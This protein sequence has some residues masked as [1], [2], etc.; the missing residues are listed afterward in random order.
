MFP[1]NSSDI[2]FSI[3]GRKR[4]DQISIVGI[5][6]ELWKRRTFIMKWGMGGIIIGLIV[7]LSLPKEY[8]T[9]MIFA[10]ERGT[11]SFN[12]LTDMSEDAYTMNMY[13]PLVASPQFCRELLKIEIPVKLGR[14]QHVKTIASIL[15]EDTKKAWWLV[16][17]QYPVTLY[18]RWIEK[19]DEDLKDIPEY[20]S[21]KELRLIDMLQQRIFLALIRRPAI[22]E[23]EVKMQDPLAAA[24]L[25]DSV[26]RRLQDLIADYR[27]AKA[28]DN[29]NHTK[30]IFE[31]AKEQYH[32][33][34]EKYAAYLDENTRV[35][36]AKS[37]IE[38]EKL[39]RES[40]IAYDFYSSMAL[41]L[42]VDFTKIHVERPVY[43]TIS[44][45]E[46]SIKPSSPNKLFI[47]ANSLFFSLFIPCVWLIFGKRG[48]SEE[49]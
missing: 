22:I 38:L 16:L 24:I 28:T 1:I 35:V 12:Q 31:E 4:D 17:L 37:K 32:S 39:S 13:S 21:A 10:P 23:L 8:T 44:P 41:K 11:P 20:F 34:Q 14:E 30:Q 25:A 15:D 49:Q 9:T 45:S 19:G 26:S 40:A 29:Y 43:F 33:V 36:K 47:M 42:Q 2:F 46:V 6:R 7:C 27:T 5:L 48:H 18:N 3:F